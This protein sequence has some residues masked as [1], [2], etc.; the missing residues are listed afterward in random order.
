VLGHQKRWLMLTATRA[1]V[2][3]PSRRGVTMIELA[4]AIAIV[5]ILAAIAAPNMSSWI[6]NLQIRTGAEAILNGLQLAR[7]QAVQRNTSILFQLTSTLD[8]SCALS[9]SSS[10]WVVSFDS[11]AGLCNSAFINE[12]FAASDAA[13]NPAPRIIQRRSAAEGS[14]DVTVAADQSTVGFNGMGRV[15]PA[16]AVA[17]NIN[18]TNPSGGLCAA[19]GG[20]MRCLRVAVSTG[21]QL[22]MCDPSLASTDPRGC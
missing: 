6:K 3:G 2:H 17:I 16:P 4:V 1:Q 12:A 13:N 18:I 10:N 15:S 11:P 8:A 9:T 20:P 21:G 14:R 5:A 22:R 19:N 7:V